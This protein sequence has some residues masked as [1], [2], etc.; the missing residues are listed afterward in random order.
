MEKKIIMS[1]KQNELK[2]IWIELME[3]DTEEAVI[4][5]LNKGGYWEN[6]DAWRYYGDRASNFNTIGNQQSRPDAALVEKLVNSVDAR[7]INECLMRGIDPEGLNAPR[8]MREAVAKFFDNG[9][10]SSAAGLIREWPSRKRTSIATGIT[11]ASTGF[12]PRQGKPCFVISLGR[13]WL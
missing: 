3:A 1:K 8:S 9:S 4:N 12:K 5:I 2:R 6:T 10:T 11:L 13:S 7:L